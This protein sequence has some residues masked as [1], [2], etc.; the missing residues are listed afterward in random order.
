MLDL[1]QSKILADTKLWIAKRRS[2]YQE[3]E[4]VQNEIDNGVYEFGQ[5]YNVEMIERIKKDLKPRIEDDEIANIKEVDGSEVYRSVYFDPD[6]EWIQEMLEYKE[7]QNVLRSYFGADFRTQLAGLIRYEDGDEEDRVGTLNWHLDSSS[8]PNSVR[9]LVFMTDQEEEG[10]F[11]LVELE[12]TEELLED[13]EY[14]ELHENPKCVEENVEVESYT[15]KRGNTLLTNVVSQ[16][17]RG[18]YPKADE[19]RFIMV[20]SFVPKWR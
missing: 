13:F 15:G 20:F 12:Q 7:L 4:E 5:L 10:A 6:E 3:N 1:A 8:P 19:T 14:G 17:H 2:S 9:L 16:L 18:R 11:E